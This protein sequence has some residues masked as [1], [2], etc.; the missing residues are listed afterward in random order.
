[1]L[2]FYRKKQTLPF[3]VC[4]GMMWPTL[5]GGVMLA[6]TP[7]P[8][9]MIQRLEKSR[10]VSADDLRRQREANAATVEAMKQLLKAYRSIPAIDGAV[11]NYLPAFY[12]TQL[13]LGP[14]A[15]F[16]SMFALQELS[17]L[18]SLSLQADSADSLVTALPDLTSLSQLSM[19]DI[20]ATTVPKLRKL[21]QQLQLLKVSLSR[22]RKSEVLPNL[23]LAHLTRVTE[24]T[25]E[26]R[27]LIVQPGDELPPNL[28]ILK[29]RDVQAAGPLL[30]LSQL[31]LL[32]MHMSTTPAGDLQEMGSH[33]PRLS[34]V[35]L[36]YTD[37][38]DAS[39]K[40]AAAGWQALPLK[41][42][43][44]RGCEGHC[45]VS[46]LEQLAKLSMLTSL[47]VY[48]GLGCCKFAGIFDVTAHGLA[49]VL[50]QMTA[51]E[52]LGLRGIKLQP[53]GTGSVNSSS[54]SNS[55]DDV[56]DELAGVAHDQQGK[57]QL[58]R[59]IASLPQLHQLAFCG[60]YSDHS[61]NVSDVQEVKLSLDPAAAVQLAAATQL[62]GLSLVDCGLNDTAVNTLASSLTGLQVLKLDSNPMVTQNV[63]PGDVARQM[64]SLK[65][66][67][68]LRT[69][70]RLGAKEFKKRLES[71]HPGLHVKS[72]AR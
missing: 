38:T 41:N 59:A 54:S 42:L 17:R 64:S 32:D 9:Q 61:G 43:E 70:I 35:R 71:L 63:L 28:A 40:Q 3:K 44:F 52:E 4:Y 11:L 29:V 5:G 56:D 16:S 69:G 24:L 45:E 67:C 55:G 19:H 48:G 10:A 58:M 21:P 39:V 8:E 46:V 6:V 47:E 36:C 31:C 60:I 15:S 14:R 68:V 51:L 7:T 26:G 53:E 25:S 33:L 13:D 34:D 27:P 1:M 2:Y 72:S 50:Q 22:I 62:T 30:S 23:Q 37:M 20:A 49:G 12:L 57:V 18:L 66:L 65:E